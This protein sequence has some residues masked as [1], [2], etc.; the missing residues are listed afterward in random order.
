MPH[1]IRTIGRRESDQSIRLQPPYERVP[2]EEDEINV[3]DLLIVLLRHKFLIMGMVFV[4]GLAA[5]VMTSE[6][7]RTYRS[8]A[9]IAPRAQETTKFFSAR[10]AGGGVSGITDEQLSIGGSG[11]QQE[12]ITELNCRKLAGM[13]VEKYKLMPILFSEGWDSDKNKWKIDAPPTIQDG[14]KVLQ[15]ML[16][17]DVPRKA[18]GSIKVGFVNKDPEMAKRFVDYY[19]TT[20]SESMR[21]EV[22]RDTAENRRFLE[23]QLGKIRDPL[24]VEKIYALLAAEIQKDTFARGQKYFGFR[25]LDPPVA[26]DLNKGEPTHRKRVLLL[27]VVVALF[28]AVFM[29][30]MIEYVRGLKTRDQ[31]RYKMLVKELKVWKIKRE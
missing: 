29:A 28:L 3:L 6:R 11:S 5:V 22:L 1:N 27:S 30:F 8:E 7:E 13:V 14:I 20:L 10:S 15:E 17:V 25:I 19:L 23:Q 12:I 9:T 18:T 24:I 2:D 21:E 26:P 4:A 31:V 16:H